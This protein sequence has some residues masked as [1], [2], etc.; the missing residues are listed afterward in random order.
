MNIVVIGASGYVGAP[1]LR[2]ALDRGHA[3]TT[4]VRYP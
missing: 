3:V 2:E 1:L 4:V